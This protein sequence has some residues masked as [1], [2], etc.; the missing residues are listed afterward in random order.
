M[1]NRR[2][3]NPSDVSLVV[4][5][6]MLMRKDA[7]QRSTRSAN[8]SMAC[9]VV[10]YGIAWRPMPNDR[11]RGPPSICRRSASWQRVGFDTLG[12]ICGPRCALPRATRRS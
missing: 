3:P 6:L 1:P 12:G 10:R 9:Y 2:K 5:Y 4:L 8:C 11:R 7:A